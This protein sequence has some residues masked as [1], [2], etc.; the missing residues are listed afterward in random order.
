MT[1]AMIECLK[2]KPCLGDQILGPEE[3]NQ[4]GQA[5]CPIP[6]QERWKTEK[7]GTELIQSNRGP[8]FRKEWQRYS[9]IEKETL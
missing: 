5:F 7:M 1:K 6:R 8:T 2:N 3:I 9:L 4:S